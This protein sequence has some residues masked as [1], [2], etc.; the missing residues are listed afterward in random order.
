MS[1]NVNGLR[2]VILTQGVSRV[3]YPL[4]RSDFN[5]VGILESAPRG[6]HGREKNIVFKIASSIYRF[7]F[8]GLTLEQVA[9]QYK[10]DYQFMVASDDPEVVEWVARLKPDVIVIHSMSQ[11]LKEEIFSIPKFGTINLHLAMLPEYRGPNPD[12][13]QYFNVE[14]NPGVT[15]HYI[16]KG[17]D[18]GDI[19]Y[20]ERVSIPLGIKSPER[21]DKLAG[22][23][24]VSLIVK[25]LHAIRNGTAPR[26]HQPKVS[27][28]LR[29]RNLK[30]DEHDR[31][32]DWNGWPGERVWH[33]LRGTELWLDAIPA[34]RGIYKGHRW[35]VQ[36]FEACRDVVA[37]PGTLSKN[38]RGTYVATID[39]RIYLTV[40]FSFKKFIIWLITRD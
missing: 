12:F 34:P 40:K 21:L 29:A 36:E 26:M 2:I 6:Y 39:G 11:L 19:I 18:T 27:S 1:D 5:V 16:D 25:A 35:V 22:E 13:W 14:L 9:E 23:V 10:L 8:N 28:T 7:F 24:G 30:A 32:I 3:V 31:V 38:K 4:L 20:Q 37:K 17:E 15:V 33:V